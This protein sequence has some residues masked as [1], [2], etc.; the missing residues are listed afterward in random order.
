MTMKGEEQVDIRLGNG[1][2]VAVVGAFADIGEV[3]WVFA[4][5]PGAGS[6]IPDPFGKHVSARLP[7]HGVAVVRVQFPYMQDGRRRPDSTAVLEETWRAA[8]DM[9]RERGAARLVI[10]G[11]SMGGRIASQVV[12]QGTGAEALVLFAYP[13]HP[14]HPPGD[15]SK[16]RDKHL[17]LIR[18]PALFCSGSRD[19]FATPGELKA[20]AEKVQRAKVHLLD[21]ADHGFAVPKASGRSRLDVWDEGVDAFVDWLAGVT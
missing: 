21:G 16:T 15:P 3:Q 18:V 2:T 13:L 7:E 17:H 8:V 12:A 9:L 4:Y 1:R 19:A 20:A 10:G 5:A 14:L 11:R 6:N